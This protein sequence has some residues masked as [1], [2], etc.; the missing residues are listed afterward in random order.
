MKRSEKILAVLSLMVFIGL[1]SGKLTQPWVGEFEAGFQEMIALHHLQSGIVNNHF[2]PVIAEIRGDKFYQTAHPP[3]LHIIYAL[4]YKIFGVGEWVTRCFSLILLIATIGLWSALL[5][6]EQRVLFWIIALFFPVSFRLGLT[7]NYEPLTIFLVALFVFSFERLNSNLNAKSLAWLIPILILLLLSDW[8]GYLAAPA[9][10]LSR[11]REAK[12][13]KWLAGLFLFELGFFLVLILYMYRVAGELAL[14]AHS[15]TRSNPLYLFQTSTWMELFEHL[16]W[17]VGLPA[18]ILVLLGTVKIA[19]ERRDGPDKFA[20]RFWGWFLVLLLGSAGQLVSRHYV[21]LLYFFLPASLI[22]SESISRIRH[23]KLAALAVLLAFILPDQAGLKT[24]DARSYYLA[25]AF[26]ASGKI[27][28]CFSSAALGALYFYDK[29][30]T[31]APVSKKATE[32]PAGIN[33]DAIILDRGSQ[34]VKG[35]ARA[36]DLGKYRQAWAFP[37]MSVYLKESPGVEFLA[38]EL[39]QE[40]GSEWWKPSAEAVY[41]DHRAWYGL[42]QVP[43]PGKMSRLEFQAGDGFFCFRP[44]IILPPGSGKSDGVNFMVM[45]EGAVK[46]EL[47]YARFV[48]NSE[49]GS[50]KIRVKDFSRIRLVVDAGPKGNFSYDDSYWLEANFGAECGGGEDGP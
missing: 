12:S 28:T 47:S 49:A 24:K 14:F 9:L 45:G 18:L 48:K 6:K 26:Q 2:L 37:E 42:R 11:I 7:T 15:G 10:L 25:Q 22:L 27:R 39:D 19:L 36:L 16:K 4:L 21:Y 13:R 8:P 40:P 38:N 3:L 34:E 50:E 41:L 30:E 46:P 31:V 43:G 23:R 32:A 1:Q 29:I 17:I 44:A 33:F 5:R 35:L 20:L